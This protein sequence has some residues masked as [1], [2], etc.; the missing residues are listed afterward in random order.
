M[1]Q[2]RIGAAVHG[3]GDIAAL[4]NGAGGVEAFTIA[5]DTQVWDFYPD[6]ASDTG[7]SA[8][9]TP[10]TASA[11]TAG[12]D[13]RGRI[14]LFAAD[15]LQ[16]NYVV[17]NAPGSSSRWGAMQVATLPLPPGAIT[18]AGIYTGEIGGALYVGAL[19]ET[20]SISPGKTYAFVY[21]VWDDNPGAF[22]AT[23][24]MVSTLNC[25]WS[26]HS[27]STAQFT[28]LD[29]VYLGYDIT[30]RQI[31]RY[32]FS[33]TFSSLSVATT[34]D[35]ASNNRYFAVLNDGNLYEMVGGS[36]GKPF[37]WA[38]LTQQQ[39]YRS[40][41][42]TLDTAGATHL[43][44]LGSN[45]DLEHLWARKDAPTAFS[46]P[47]VVQ[48]NVALMAVTALDQGDVQ[49]FAIGTAQATLIQLIWQAGA[50][51]W[52][53]T[54]VEVPTSG[55]VEEFV[56]YSTDLQIRDAAGA[57]V[58]KAVVQ[59]RASSQ[60]QITVNGGFYTVDPST[61]A[62]LT[63]SAA[64]TL[65]ITQQTDTLVIP[66]LQF[67][68]AS[69]T[70]A[71]LAVQQFAGVQQQLATVT[72]DQLKAAKKADG[73]YLL[74]DKYR[75]DK[76]T[77]DAVASA[78]NQAMAIAA[79][80]KR[81]APLAATRH[82]HKPGVGTIPAGSLAD[83]HRIVVEPGRDGPHWQIDFSTGQARFRTL[84]ADEARAL[85]VEKLA[86]HPTP[87]RA[88]G[89]LDWIGSIGDLIEG[90]ANKIV[91]V[92]DT[93]V[94]TVGNAIHA[95]LTFVID[96]ITYVFNAVVNV[97]EQ[98]FD[99]V[100]VVFARVA[101]FFSDLFQWLGF[102]FAWGDI[103]RTHKA[104]VYTANQFLGFLP[105]A[106]GGVQRYI[107]NGIATV[108]SQ[109]PA[110]F[111][112]L[113]A[114]VGGAS[115]GGY[116]DAKT[117]SEPTF[118][119]SNANNIVLNGTIDNAA[120]AR[121]T[122]I[123]PTTMGPFDSVR[124]LIVQLVDAVQGQPAFQQALDYM[125]NLGGNPDQIFVQL[126]SAL[127]RVVQGLAQAMLSGAQI[128]VDAVL[129]LVQGFMAGI[130]STLNESWDIP[131]V[132][133]F[134]GWLTDGAPL[135]L[136]DLLCLILAIPATVLFKATQHAAP[137]PDDASVAAFEASFTAQTML[138]NSGLGTHQTTALARSAAPAV[139]DPKPA[140]QVL[141]SAAGFLSFAGY[142]LLSAA[143]DV[144]PMTGGHVVDP[145]VKTLTKIALALEII[146]QAV[147]CPWIYGASAP[148][149]TD[150]EGAGGVF[151]IYETV[152]VALDAGFTWY[153]SAFPE[154]ND[155]YW[156]IGIAE[157]Y[158]V[159][160]AIVTGVLGSK[161]SGVGLAS[162]IVLLIPECCKFLR[163]PQIE[164]A[165]EGWSLIGIA[166]LDGLCIPASG[167]LSFVDSITPAAHT[168][169]AAPLRIQGAV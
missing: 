9:A 112:R 106:I 79:M 66:T 82:G 30:T 165:S 5:T 11:V 42:V 18:I 122:P 145:L 146:A 158:G 154:N 17:E 95:V 35:A 148:N 50:G 7:V 84:T 125:T 119:S 109:I 101:A 10:L 137:F 93:V 150:A 37:S 76:S 149:C 115:L 12:R 96:G 83:L 72:G 132:T 54:P 121:Y 107:D 108:Q 43:F 34:L 155:T 58:P 136:L 139:G 140:W 90:I 94:T 135:T 138:A 152:G 39:S 144:K 99:L 128:V 69:V 40:V 166:A 116:V 63:A 31:V 59:V 48:S 20:Q 60:T 141:L 110:I 56:S 92:I 65:T 124:Q 49:L 41:A 91:D 129:G 33:S 15:H 44:A 14:V 133:A 80:T 167:L 45:G 86:R 161:L 36:G 6:T 85:M 52:Q 27:A 70:T 24:M 73:N 127:L 142:G 89:F 74:P 23:T 16:I 100:Q 2:Y 75:N 38:Q 169:H 28:C 130:Q 61:P 62:T 19:I 159:G 163:L 160:H 104:L 55:Q 157:L 46:T 3:G 68:I 168:E 87:D 147:A 97:I 1:Q 103:L 113:V 8:V 29:V 53:V 26:G 111:D 81:P 126:A 118:S 77:T 134:Y 153:D 13:R 88:G 78:C 102:L 64:G 164:T 22:T 4:Q 143:M 32:P 51:N 71:P 67:E 156:G 114:A 105:L 57:P 151:W 25:V 162:K 123:D 21:S 120:G 117:P 131:F 98:A 47:A